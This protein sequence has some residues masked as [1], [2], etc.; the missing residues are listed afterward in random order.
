MMLGV[1]FTPVGKMLKNFPWEVV[2]LVALG[3]LAMIG[4][5]WGCLWLMGIRHLSDIVVPLDEEDREDD[6]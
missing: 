2:P 4:V 1:S 3:I 6:D 5:L